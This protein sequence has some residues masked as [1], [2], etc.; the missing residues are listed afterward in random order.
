MAQ[1]KAEV[2]IQ[3]AGLTSPLP[4]PIPCISP[5][6]DFDLHQNKLETPVN[7]KRNLFQ[8]RFVGFN[9]IENPTTHG[10]AQPKSSTKSS[11]LLS[12]H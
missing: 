5:L 7:N 2:F 8:M 6:T 1:K 3:P 11:P 12:V 10:K 9:E 4:P